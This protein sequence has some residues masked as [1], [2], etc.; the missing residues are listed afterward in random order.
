MGNNNH[1]KSISLLLLVSLVFSSC[2][3]DN[4]DQNGA[5]LTS[6]ETL[7]AGHI[8][9]ES[10][11][12]NQ[13]GLLSTFPEAFAI[14]TESGL[15]AGPSLLTTGSF[16]NMEDYSYEF[17]ANS[18]VHQVTFTRQNDNQFFNSSSTY[19]LNY[20]FYDHGD[21][22]VENPDQRPFDIEMVDFRATRS[23]EIQADS[24][25]STF[26]RIDQLFMDGLSSESDVISID[27]FHSGEGTFTRIQTDG[28]S[29]Q[30]EYLLDINY[31]DIR[32]NKSTVKSNR[33]FRSGVTG[34]LS[35]ESTVHHN[36]TSDS[37]TKAVNGTIEMNGDGTALLTFREQFDN[38]Y[39]LHL[40]EGD[41]FDEDKFE[42]RITQVNLQEMIFTISNGQRIQ[43]TEE[44]ELDDGDFST[45]EEVSGAVETGVRV[46]AEGDYYHPD[47]SV[48]LWIATEVEFE[49]ESNEFEDLVASADPDQHSFTLSNG[50][51]FYIAESSEV[52]FDDGIASFEDLAG[53]VQMGIP[54][55][56]EGEF[57]VDADTGYRMVTKVEFEL[58]IDDYEEFDGDVVSV[59]VDENYFT[60]ESGDQIKL[61]EHTIIDEESEYFSLQEV[62]DALEK[63]EEVEAEGAFH[64]EETSGFRIA[65]IVEFS[66]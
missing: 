62:A 49:L 6:E 51:R 16:R 41:V 19:T 43:V 63:D 5:I 1:Y 2:T 58:E 46:F 9:G 54:V 4:F 44:T 48:N 3:V 24:K 40:D 22:P 42:G 12:E 56:A 60:L 61:T 47:E 21:D 30:R 50:D 33:N 59:T 39:R 31:L 25:I 17:D 23:G 37:E 34:A 57:Y 65:V 64:E 35:Y 10:V 26:T 20:T 36:G 29:I 7:I 18:G 38:T 8:I 53:A 66:N 28:S 55:E 11:S 45:L 32:I 27:G 14:P 52:E 13:N 15:T